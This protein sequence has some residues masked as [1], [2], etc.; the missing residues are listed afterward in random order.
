MQE[1]WAGGF[2]EALNVE[3]QISSVSKDTDTVIM[4]T[5]Y[6][7]VPPAPHNAFRGIASSILTRWSLSEM[8]LKPDVLAEYAAERMV[9]VRPTVSTYVS[10]DDELTLEDDSG[11]LPLV[12]ATGS[13]AAAALNKVRA[14]L[15]A[16]NCQP[17]CVRA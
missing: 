16:Y 2:I 14:M 4:G 5:L 7:C 1:K 9:S 17:S 6:R 3:D 15:P 11:R 13:H 12:A 10:E 8:K